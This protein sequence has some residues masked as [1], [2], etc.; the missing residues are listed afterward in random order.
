MYL[1]KNTTKEVKLA[2]N[3]S[4]E[5]CLLEPGGSWETKILPKDFDGLEVSLKGE[6]KKNKK[7]VDE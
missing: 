5:T 2:W 4:G 3:V 7:E 1:V 6:K